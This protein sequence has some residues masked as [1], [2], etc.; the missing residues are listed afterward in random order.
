ADIDAHH[1]GAAS[2][3][4]NGLMEAEALAAIFARHLR[5]TDVISTD[6]MYQVV[7]EKE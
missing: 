5:V 6:E 1:H 7:G 3:V 4:S 2:R